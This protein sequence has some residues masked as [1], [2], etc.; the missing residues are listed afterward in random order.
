MEKGWKHKM[1]TGGG[2]GKKGRYHILGEIKG[3]SPVFYASTND[4]NS[5]SKLVEQA[6]KDLYD[7]TEKK[8]KIFVTD[9]INDEELY[10]YAQ[11]GGV[12]NGYN[13]KSNEQIWN[14][15][16][17][18]QRKH[19]L[20]DHLVLMSST[21]DHRASLYRYDELPYNLLNKIQPKL[22]EHI[23]EG[24]YAQGGEVG[25]KVFNTMYGV[26]S[27]KYV[28]NYHDGVKTHKDGS[29][30]FDIATFKNK[31]DFNKFVNKLKKDGYVQGHEH[32]GKMAKGGGV[33]SKTNTY[34]LRAEGLSDFLAFLQQG[35]YFR[36][37]S[38]TVETTSGPDV[39]VSFK[40]D[41]S[42][43]EIKSKLN[44]VPDSHVMLETI[45]PIKEYTGE[46][47]EEYAK[48]G[49]VGETKLEKLKREGKLK[50]LIEVNGKKYFQT[51]LPNKQ[52]KGYWKRYYSTNQSSVGVLQNS[53]LDEDDLINLFEQ[54]S[55]KM[56]KGGGVGS[57][58][59]LKYSL[60]LDRTVGD[61][62]TTYHIADFAAKGD[63]SIALESLKAAAPK[64]YIY[65]TK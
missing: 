10:N 23:S 22:K 7:L 25:K 41:A 61:N 29:E 39:V 40:T 45:K 48:G 18:E 9:S 54:Q 11:G 1:A 55:T 65:Y 36:V 16:S 12:G 13:N 5:I 47:N 20:K 44:E 62:V 59:K 64:N 56:A 60:Y 4:K 14:N 49:G 19:F 58:S 52:E 3:K 31:V 15:W 35:M 2:I 37:K 34:K 32:G 8:H 51:I 38:F 63:L 26:G 24:Q 28:V 50:T 53:M 43:S 17:L 33:G 21:E 6:D 57:S 42:L 46:R 30:F 27:S